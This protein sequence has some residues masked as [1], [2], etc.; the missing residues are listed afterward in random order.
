MNKKTLKA[1]KLS[2]KHWEENL[3]HAKDNDLDKINIGTTYCALCVLY[4]KKICFGCPVFNVTGMI[5]C[6]GSPY[7][8]VVELIKYNKSDGMVK[9]CSDE[10]EFLKSLLPERDTNG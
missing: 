2:I 3:S 5:D 7:I 10:V 9:A 6:K 1:L 4:F 8:A